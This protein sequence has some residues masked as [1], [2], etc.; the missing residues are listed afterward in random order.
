MEITSNIHK[1]DR[2]RGAN[3]YLVLGDDGA[4][5]IDT[6]LPRNGERIAEYSK[7]VGVGPAGL[8]YVI[9]THSDPDHSGS[10]S[11]LKGLTGAKI[12]IHELDAPRLSGDKKRKE[13]RGTAGV[14]FGIVSPFM[15]VEPVKADI[16]L[17]DGDRILGLRVVHTPGHTEGSVCLYKE[18][19]AI[20]VGDALRTDS[21]GRVHL[22]S[23][24]MTADMGR[25]K[26]SARK[27][28]ELRCTML[29]P[30]HGPPI[31][32]DAFKALGEFAKGL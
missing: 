1:I 24:S 21:G 32:Q 15:R 11:K 27:I 25:A 31:T 26:E 6:G 2:I 8:R 13:V 14:L 16:L 10:V 3:S 28:S 29:L 17:K 23:A 18:D 9:L 30:G 7:E 4:A 22:P 12:A 5:V 19:E 20:F